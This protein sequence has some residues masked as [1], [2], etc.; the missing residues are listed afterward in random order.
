MKIAIA[1]DHGGVELKKELVDYL[2]NNHEV[3]DLSM[4]NTSTDDYPD[5]AYVVGKSIQ[6]KET[7]LGILICA[8]GS[9]M[10]ITANK[11]N[12]VYCVKANTVEEAKL[13]REHNGANTI[14]LSGSIDSTLA[15][16]MIEAFI[17]AQPLNDERHQRR[18]DKIIK[19]ESAEYNGL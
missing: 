11:I 5:F 18:Y 13:S 7:D 10:C 6:N 14:A 2:S 1:S 16:E 19:I 3:L 12:S 9:G 15:K 4:E 8:S 17:N